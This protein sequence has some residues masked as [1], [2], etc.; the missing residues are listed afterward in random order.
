VDTIIKLTPSSLTNIPI[1]MEME[2]SPLLSGGLSLLTG[3]GIPYSISGTTKA[4]RGG[5]KW[6]IPFEQTGT[7]TTKDL[8][9]LGF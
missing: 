5:I 8:G 6:N 4:G 1:E 9:Q 3:G 2:T 7:F